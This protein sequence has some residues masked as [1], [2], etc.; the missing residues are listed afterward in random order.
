MEKKAQDPLVFSVFNEIG[1]IDQ[2]ATTQLERVLPD[3][4]KIS[5]FAVLN[6]FARL[7]GEESPVQLARAFQVTK[8][9][10]TNTL[11]RLETRG[12]ITIRPDPRDGRAKLV[13][14][15]AAGLDQR[16]RAIKAVAPLMARLVAQIPE[17]DFAAA[18]PFLQRLRAYLDEMR[19]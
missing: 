13:A 6:H 15:T 1:I 7:G 17:E 18:L 8:G 10:I 11:Q 9:A 16:D 2:L 19:N 5:H 12:L 14:I 3:G 4:M